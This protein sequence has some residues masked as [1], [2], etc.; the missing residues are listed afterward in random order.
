LKSAPV[1]LSTGFAAPAIFF[2]LGV[3]DLAIT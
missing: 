2:C 1:I 3:N